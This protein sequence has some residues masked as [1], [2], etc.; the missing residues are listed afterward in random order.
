MVKWVRIHLASAGVM[1]LIPSPGR[2]H[3]V[4]QLSLCT[5]GLLSP[6]SRAHELQLLTPEHLEP[7]V[8]NKGSHH[9]EKPCTATREQPPLA[10][11]Q[12]KSACS[13]EDNG[14]KNKIKK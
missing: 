10:I 3:A 2:F 5:A 4:E 7:V 6:S 14:Q 13:K 11:I 9:S 1:S 12:R 8:S